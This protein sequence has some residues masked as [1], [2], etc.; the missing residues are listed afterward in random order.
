MEVNKVSIII[1]N[2][3]G[4]E[5]LKDCLNSLLQ[6]NYENF[7]IILVDNNSQD[8]SVEFVKKV[9]PMVII[10][11]LDKNKGF[12][13]PN[14]IGAKNAKGDFL[15]FLNNDTKV[16]PNFLSELVKVM[17]QDSQISICQSL[18]VKPS[19]EIDSSGDFVDIYGR[20]FSN[21]EKPNEVKPILSGKGASILVR[22]NIFWELGGFDENFSVS[23]E[24]VEIGWKSWL[25]NYKVM[26]APNSLV[27]HLAGK[28]TSQ[29][30]EKTQF[31]GV[32]NTLVLVLTFFE[33][34]Y[35]LRALFMLIFSNVLKKSLGNRIGKNSKKI[36]EFPTYR[37]IFKGICWVIRNYKY[38]QSKRR[39]T[40]SRRVLTTQKLIEMG[41]ISYSD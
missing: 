13:E 12:A 18:L 20:V 8:D 39:E 21:K 23:F 33:F 38:I 36:Q 26:I 7:E 35:I 15:L 17:N 24:D 41:L 22:K 5:Y 30:K 31:H 14:N 4:K 2:F 19:G 16:T 34:S 40:N 3:N 9:F 1:V 29:L 28:T 32:K 10:I 25:W 37:T 27:I 6:I 11:K